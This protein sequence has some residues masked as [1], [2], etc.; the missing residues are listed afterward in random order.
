MMLE[1]G[2]LIQLSEDVVFS[3][4]QFK[5]IMNDV[6]EYLSA[7]PTITVADFRDRYQTSRKYAL[8]FLEYLD[9]INVTRR[10]G[11]FRRLVKRN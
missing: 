11:D 5:K 9:R 2:D 1:T 4:D 6:V 3:G 10:D 7:K 8:A